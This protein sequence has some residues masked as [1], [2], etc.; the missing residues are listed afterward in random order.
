MENGYDKEP[1]K[2]GY[3]THIFYAVLSDSNNIRFIT[4]QIYSPQ[5]YYRVIKK[6]TVYL[7]ITVQKTR[8]NILNSFNHL[9]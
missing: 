4:E 8:K 1:R 9:P 5:T 3:M 7:M 6:V 2:L